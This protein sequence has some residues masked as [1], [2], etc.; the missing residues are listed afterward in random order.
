MHLLKKVADIRENLSRKLYVSTGIM[1][2]E[3]FDEAINSKSYQAV[4][5][6]QT[7]SAWS[8]DDRAALAAK[9]KKIWQAIKE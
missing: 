8:A 4:R 1:T 2:P 5:T 9:A 7:W 6:F 3:K